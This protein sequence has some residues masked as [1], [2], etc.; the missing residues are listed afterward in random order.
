M[1][2]LTEMEKMLSWV[3]GGEDSQPYSQKE[4]PSP[5]DMD[6][7]DLESVLGEMARIE[8]VCV[9]VCVSVCVCAQHTKHVHT[10]TRPSWYIIC[11]A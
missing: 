9:C 7:I 8:G 10:C 6:Q 5:P 4:D 3:G 11:K 1:Q 2:E